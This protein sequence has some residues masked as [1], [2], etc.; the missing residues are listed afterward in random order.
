MGFND[1]PYEEDYNSFI[2]V[3]NCVTSAILIII[4]ILALYKQIKHQKETPSHRLL[5]IFT[6]LFYLSVILYGFALPINIVIWCDS[7]L[8]YLRNWVIY[9]FF[10]FIS[11]DIH[12]LLLMIVLFSR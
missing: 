12:W 2:F 7:T 5:Y 11:H 3:F 6:I 10:T 4:G 1:C 9:W 8:D